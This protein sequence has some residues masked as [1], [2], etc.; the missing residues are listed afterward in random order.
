[1][2]GK[3]LK[4]NLLNCYSDLQRAAI[5]FY[6]NPRGNNHQVFLSHACQI[7]KKVSGRKAKVFGKLIALLA[8]KVDLAPENQKI[9]FAD[10]IL[11]TGILI[12]GLDKR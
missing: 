10:K 12:K 8:K 4:I 9:N 11:T 6:L 3:E 7:L 5:A 1:M 2:S